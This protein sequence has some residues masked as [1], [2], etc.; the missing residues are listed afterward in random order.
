MSLPCTWGGYFL[1]RV[2]FSFQERTGSVRLVLPFCIAFYFG[3][4]ALFACS[5]NL[6]ARYRNLLIAFIKVVSI[7]AACIVVSPS[8]TLFAKL[9]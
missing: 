7:Y 1:Y 2:F 4:G 8:L 9:T 5:R 3:C 6:H